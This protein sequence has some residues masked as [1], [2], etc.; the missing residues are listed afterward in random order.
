MVEQHESTPEDL[1]Q[2]LEGLH[3]RLDEVQQR[4][5]K[6]TFRD[7]QEDVYGELTMVDQHEADYG[8]ET[9]DRELSLTQEE[10]LESEKREI[11]EAL[12]K[13]QVGTYGICESC[14]QQIDPERLKA[15]PYS[16]LCVDCQRERERQ[17][18]RQTP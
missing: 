13:Q 3:Q 11:A 1:Q 5:H 7:T 9:F 15:R 2:Q 4:I 12:H 14:G 16:V 8:T 10:I 18:Y 17:M 6:D